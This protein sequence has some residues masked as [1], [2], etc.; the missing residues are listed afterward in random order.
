MGTLIIM[1]LTFIG[2]LYNY[3]F[4]NNYVGFIFML[5][6][7]YLLWRYKKDGKNKKN[8]SQY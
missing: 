7:L 2:M 5:V 3:G 8:N 1:F 4:G 6:F